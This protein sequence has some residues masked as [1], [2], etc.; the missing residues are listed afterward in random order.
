MSTLQLHAKLHTGNFKDSTAGMC[1]RGK[2][3]G[4]G[5]ELMMH[6]PIGAQSH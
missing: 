3:F 4:S 1:L 5:C 6:R 2:R